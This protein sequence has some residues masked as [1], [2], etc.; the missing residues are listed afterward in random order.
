[1]IFFLSDPSDSKMHMPMSKIHKLYC[2]VDET[3]Q[4]TLG[5]LFVVA[6]VV[7]DERQQELEKYLEILERAS[8]KHKR[9]WVKS[10]DQERQMYIRA[11][12]DQKMPGTYS[13]KATRMT[14]SALTD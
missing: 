9:K 7:T 5:A 2:F 1:M 8:G 11:L 13:L 3:G 4:D 6:I 14:Q 12:L 10:R